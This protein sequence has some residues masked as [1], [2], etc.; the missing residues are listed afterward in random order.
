[1]DKEREYRISCALKDL[2]H[3][4]LV[5]VASIH[6]VSRGS[7]RNRKK[8]GTNARDAQIPAQKLDLDQER[9]LVNW[10]LNEEAAGRGQSRGNIRMFADLILKH[11]RRDEHVG[12]NWV[13][14][15]IARHEDIKMKPS[16]S[17]DAIRVNETT[18]ESLQRFFRLLDTTPAVIFTGQ[19]LQGQWS[20]PPWP[21]WKY[22]YT[23]TG[24]SNSL[25]FRKWFVE[26]FLP[27]TEPPPGKWRLLILDGHSSHVTVEIIFLAW[28]NKVQLLY[29]P[30][31]SSHMTQP[32]DVG[33]F[34]ILK[35]FFHQ[36]TA[37]YATFA[38]RSPI[39]KRRFIHSYEIARKKALTER[40]IRHSFRGAG[41]YP[42]DVEKPIK[43]VIN[44]K[45][46]PP[47]DLTPLTPKKQKPLARDNLYTPKN[48]RDIIRR[49]DQ[50][51]SGDSDVNREA[52]YLIKQNGKQITHLNSIVATQK[53]RIEFLED[54]LES[55][56]PT[57]RKAV[58]YDP[59]ER[60][61]RIE[62]IAYA[63]YEAE[64]APT[65]YRDREAPKLQ[66][67]PIKA[68]EKEAQGLQSVFQ[69]QLN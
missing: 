25:I 12:K 32:L 7:L 40:N 18:E 1:M 31:H 26:V 10:I 23:S 45:R 42:V 28:L 63:H 67:N 24:W 27:E 53:Q 52:R 62:E 29:L 3:A 30:A 22:D 19:N 60:F 39:Q 68:A 37:K 33:I 17:T 55:Q 57:G 34:A 20:D 13:D 16:R 49:L 69:V 6:A 47:P 8:G 36:E 65:K 58:D 15:F 5:Q 9:N 43:K 44:T 35:R 14:R 41:L 64:K 4:P 56:K 61:A 50:A 54:K 48:N 38:A 46:P 21:D 11:D 51:R 66:E 59:N 2:K